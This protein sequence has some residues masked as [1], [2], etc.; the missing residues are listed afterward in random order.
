[1]LKPAILYEDILQGRYLENIFQDRFK[2]YSRHSGLNYLIPIAQN[3]ADM[4]QLV[5]LDDTGK[6]VGYFGARI[7]RE[8]NT[9]YDLEAMSFEGKNDTFSADLCDFV[10]FI[11]TKFGAERMTWN[12]VVGNPAEN[13]YDRLSGN[14]GG[15]VVGTFRN[16]VKLFDG[17]LCD[18]K[19][20]ELFK[21][22]YFKSLEKAGVD[23]Q[24]WRDYKNGG[25]ANE[26][27]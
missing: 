6:V 19:W 18:L 10:G 13:L 2:F 11:F 20:Y 12:V 4:L 1:M 27:Q 17:Q 22:D 16:E 3:T 14:Y 7:N 15:R 23:R 9:A 24:A 26:R 5:S 25:V 21:S 8:T